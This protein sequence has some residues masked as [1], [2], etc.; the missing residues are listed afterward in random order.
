MTKT[1]SP[2][3]PKIDLSKV[4]DPERFPSTKFSPHEELLSQVILDDDSSSV[5][6]SEEDD[7]D[8]EVNS[9]SSSEQEWDSDSDLDDYSTSSDTSSDFSDE[10]T[11][12]MIIGLG[13][14]NYLQQDTSMN[15][16]NPFKNATFDNNRRPKSDATVVSSMAIC[17]DLMKR[18]D[19]VNEAAAAQPKPQ[20][21]VQVA[22]PLFPAKSRQAF[23]RTASIANFE[24]L[25][26]AAKDENG[27]PIRKVGL[28]PAERR[29]AFSKTSSI[30]NFQAMRHKAG[31]ESLEQ[32]KKVLYDLAD[33]PAPSEI[34]PEEYLVSLLGKQPIKLAYNSLTGFFLE[35]NEDH[36]NAWCTE[37]VGTIRSRDL[38]ALKRQYKSGKQLQ[39]C[40]QFGESIIHLCVRRGTPEMLSFLVNKAHLSIRVCCDYG[41]T[42][43]HDAC[44]C[45]SSDHVD[46]LR[47]MEIILRECPMMLCIT[48][49]R[50]FTPLDY[51]PKSMWAE[52]RNLLKKMH[53]EG[54]LYSLQ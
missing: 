42:P 52:C 3:S 15:V 34:S 45:L 19:S 48:D 44:W 2:P 11:Q 21:G 1:A 30:A 18:V 5:S 13:L 26:H 9:V 36:V 39:A 54:L 23:S 31:F 22:R 38:A 49:K 25:G 37:L 53:K 17:K 24:A 27:E 50:N 33:I 14:A 12:A 29:A 7:D 47:M 10:E 46:A 8:S 16:P 40:N 35:G 51:V 32:A 6:S 28:T 43:L 41:K 4:L 20:Q